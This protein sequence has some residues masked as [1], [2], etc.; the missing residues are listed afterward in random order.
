MYLDETFNEL[1]SLHIVFDW[2]KIFEWILIE[3]AVWLWLRLFILCFKRAQQDVPFNIRLFTMHTVF[4]AICF[5]RYFITWHSCML[6]WFRSDS[7]FFLCS[8]N[9]L[10]VNLVKWIRLWT[11]FLHPS[12][13]HG[14]LCYFKISVFSFQLKVIQHILWDLYCFVFFL[15]NLVEFWK[16]SACMPVCF[17]NSKETN[18]FR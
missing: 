10:G 16:Y 8:L 15:R 5:S 7:S 18:F 12:I 9:C 3:C 11:H 17:P 2:F 6:H 1:Y 13:R 4:V 14:S